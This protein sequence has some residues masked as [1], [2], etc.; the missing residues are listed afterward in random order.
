[1]GQPAQ[2]RL[3]RLLPALIAGGTRRGRATAS[4][5]LPSGQES[6]RRAHRHPGRRSRRGRRR[7]VGHADAGRRDRC[8]PRRRH[9]PRADAPPGVADQFEATHRLDERGAAAAR[10]PLSAED[11]HAAPS[12]RPSPRPSTR[13]TSTRWSTWPPKTLELNEIGV[14]NLSLDQPIAFDPYDREPRHRRLHPDRPDDQRHGR[15]R[16]DPLRAAPRRRTSTGR[17]STSTSRRAPRSRARSRA[18]CGSPACP[19]PASRPSPTWSRS[20]CYAAGRHTYLLDGD[21]VRHGLNRDLGFTDADRVENIRRVAEVAQ[22]D[23]RRRPDRAGRRSSR[24]SAPSAQLAR[25]LVG[26]GRVHRG[27]RR[28]AAGRRR[29]ARR[30]GPL[31]EGARAASSRTSPAS[32][33]PTRRPRT[34][35]SASTRPP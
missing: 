10:P 29:A 24:R 26:A 31:Q 3:P 16:P 4:R 34:P 7:P 27:L 21:N 28:H 30:Q 15:R 25:E 1:M 12:A 19:A 22:A 11:R 2:P 9:L 23:G 17:R 32:T 33:A 6:T 8:Q 13:S 5:V 20:S 35:R 14:C 18:C